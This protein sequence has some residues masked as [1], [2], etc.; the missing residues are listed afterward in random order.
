MNH[1]SVYD[2]R[3]ARA[4]TLAAEIP[5]ASEALTFYA[6]LAEYQRALLDGA[7]GVAFTARASDRGPVSIAAS[8]DREAI[9]SAIPGFLSWLPRAAP[10]RLAESAATLVETDRDEWRQILSACVEGK[11]DDEIEPSRRFVIAA[12]LQPHAELAAA[13]IENRS[14]DRTSPRCPACGGRPMVGV[15]RGEGH[16]AKRA[17]ICGLCLTEHE[18]L[19]LVCPGCGEEQFERLP[20]YTSDAFPHVRID[21]C[22]SCRRYL[23]VVDLTRDGHA[24]PPV[25]DIASVSLDLWARERAY[26]RLHPNILA[27]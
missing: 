15:L 7:G 8:I 27:L 20:V 12:V 9:L 2:Q 26:A 23:K 16:G 24:V 10:P 1:H 4:R 3:I 6:G 11:A 19:R 21:A 25:D 5:A 14:V 13:H 17:L 18:F 22:D